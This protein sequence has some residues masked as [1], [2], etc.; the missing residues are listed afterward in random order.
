MPFLLDTCAISEF[1]TAQ[2][3][4]HAIQYLIALP[5]AEI[6]LSAITIGE[7]DRGIAES[8]T[9][10]RKAFLQTWLDE[11]VLP[12]Y[13]ERTLP[14][15]ITVARQW[16]SL[17]ASLTRRGLKMQIADSLIAA[18]AVVHGLTVVT[19]NESD[20]ASSKVHIL[21]PWK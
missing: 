5:R 14:V 16:G 2:P 7:L 9:G 11:H 12:L 18:T 10:K 8:Q 4:P 20:F 19:R 3:D 13:A 1:V 15:D 17:A 21:N 6:Y